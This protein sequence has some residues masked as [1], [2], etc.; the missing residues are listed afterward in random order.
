MT[1]PPS[2]LSKSELAALISTSSLSVTEVDSPS[3]FI[4]TSATISAS[5]SGE[6]AESEVVLSP[7][8]KAC[9]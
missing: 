2:S 3:G 1:F 4:N 5:L 6:M 7:K 9:N 8:I